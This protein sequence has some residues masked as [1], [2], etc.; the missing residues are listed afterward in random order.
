MIIKIKRGI[1]KQDEEEEYN[2]KIAAVQ[3]RMQKA[4]LHLSNLNKYTGKNVAKMNTLNL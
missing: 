3:G 1:K 4:G 2:R